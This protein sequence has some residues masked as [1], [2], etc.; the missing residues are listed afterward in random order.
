ME[1]IRWLH[2][3]PCGDLLS[4]MPS[5]KESYE[6]TG[7]KSVIYQRVNVPYAEFGAYPGAQY[8]IK[9][10][11]GLPVTMSEEVFNAVKPLMLSQEYIQDFLIWD[12]NE[13]DHNLDMLRQHDTPM[14]FGSINAYLPFIIPATACDLSKPWLN[15]PYFIKQDAI[16]KI[17]INRTQRYNNMYI[18]YNFL[19][20]YE[21]SVLFV[22]LPDEY[23]W[24]CKQNN[25]SIPR[26][27]AKDYFE[28]AVALYNCK[29]Y[30]GNQSSLWQVAEGQKISRILEVCKSIPNVIGY[31]PN[32]YQFL[33]QE[34]LEY[35]VNK[36]FNS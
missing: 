14:P 4:L 34:A 36:L 33:K 11:N 13:V 6:S 10:K 31:G 17:I 12:G 21:G 16:G 27:E 29:L 15:I 3:M 19:K 35:Y 18:S 20:K 32:F 5:F 26:L 2:T 24:F 23:E 25:L 9:D 7:C 1:I 28:I 8:S 22:G 30:I